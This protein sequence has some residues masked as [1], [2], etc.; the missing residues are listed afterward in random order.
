MAVR[1]AGPVSAASLFEGVRRR[2]V[3]AMAAWLAATA[4]LGWRASL[5]PQ[6]NSLDVWLP[7]GDEAAELYREFRRTFSVADPLVVDFPATPPERLEPTVRRLR[8]EASVRQVH[9]LGTEKGALIALFPEPDATGADLVR[10][11]GRVPIAIEEGLPGETRHL[12]GVWW[13]N[14]AIDM[15]S[16][17]AVRTLFPVVLALMGAS[18]LVLLRSARDA[19]IALGAG[20][21]PVAQL[22]GLMELCGQPL[23]LLL[24]ALPPL[25]LIL[26]VTYS[27][28]MLVQSR[29]AARG[30]RSREF[31]RVVVPTLAAAVTTVLGFASLLTSSLGPV[32]ALGVWGGVGVLLSLATTFVLVP[33]CAGEASEAAAGPGARRRIPR[34]W[35]ILIAV[36]ALVLSAVGAARLRTESHVL[37]FFEPSAEV[38]RDYDAIE[39]RGLG[40]TPIE[41]WIGPSDAAERVSE[42]VRALAGRRGE[43]THLVWS[44][45]AGPGLPVA[46]AGGRPLA[47]HFLP[48]D[49][50]LARRVRGVASEAGRRA[51]LFTRTLTIEG[52]I[53]LIRDL[54]RTL[55]EALGPA[56]RP[57]VTGAVALLVRMQAL[58]AQTLRN[59]FAG[60]FLTIGLVMVLT[61]RSVGLGLFAL[62]PNVL[63]VVWLLGA[64]GWLGMPLDLATVSVASIAFGVLV[65]DTIHFLH[66]YR[67]HRAAGEGPEAA[68]RGVLA[69]SGRAMIAAT[70]VSGV[71]FLG[72]LAS[73]FVPLRN[74]GLLTSLTLW[75]GVS[76]DLLL[77]PALILAFRRKEA[78]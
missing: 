66:A 51:T 8:A 9:L 3:A 69:R 58:L 13:L 21:L 53:A 17:R 57:R 11:A 24:A 10:L 22:G 20:A 43:I 28:H 56:P 4:L 6:D 76:C 61:L 59:S 47:L 29:G 18:L 26:G 65:D 41:L 72:F 37:S 62:V 36:A 12:G 25:T 73:P 33:A 35:P 19:A 38:R 48:E 23:N 77:V 16:D 70:A 32:R 30:T 15:G 31:A 2:R 45:D 52:T 71:S 34:G 27:V 1:V 5:L 50:V 63:P 75:L 42:A 60:A 44:D 14:R 55:G 54:E 7:R 46:M 39:R 49:R 74:F 64:M 40:L 78:H 68:V 67:E